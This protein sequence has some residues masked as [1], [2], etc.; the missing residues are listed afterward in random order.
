MVV[1]DCIHEP[2]DPVDRAISYLLNAPVENSMGKIVIRTIVKSRDTCSVE[3]SEAEAWKC[4]NT[5]DTE[6]EKGVFCFFF[7]LKR[8]YIHNLANMVVKGMK[9]A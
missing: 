4:G 5:K 7:Q 1:V 6:S 9:I 3:R 8:M 2:N